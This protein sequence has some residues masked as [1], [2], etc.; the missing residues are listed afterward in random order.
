MV[1]LTKATLV[2][3]TLEAETV[4]L[5]TKVA[6]SP[7]VKLPIVHLEPTKEPLETLTT[8]AP[9]NSLGITSS[10]YASTAESG[11]LLV[12]VIVQITTS[13]R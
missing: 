10:T 8:A 13:P 11:P 5:I 3:L 7:L 2:I 1:E 9:V 12:T 6:F 4:V